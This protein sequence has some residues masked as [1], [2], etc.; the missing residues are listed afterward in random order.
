MRL[1]VFEIDQQIFFEHLPFKGRHILV[2]VSVHAILDEEIF[3]QPPQPVEGRNPPVPDV[4]FD[5]L[6]FEIGILCKPERVV[7]E[8]SLHIRHPLLVCRALRAGDP[9]VSFQDRILNPGVHCF[10]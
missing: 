4:P 6:R 1:C 5:L 9:L 2:R 8:L 7:G 3:Q 10:E